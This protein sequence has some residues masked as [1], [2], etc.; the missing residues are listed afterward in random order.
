L[1]ASTFIIETEDLD[2]LNQLRAWYYTRFGPR[3]QV[4]NDLVDKMV[5][6]VWNEKRAW[7]MEHE[8]IN[9]QMVRMAPD[10]AVRFSQLSPIAR[11]ACAFAELARTLALPLL[12][13]YAARL[14][15]EFH[16]SMKTLLELQKTVPLLP[17]GATPPD[18]IQ[19]DSETNPCPDSDTPVPT[20]ESSEPAAETSNLADRPSVVTAPS[21]SPLPTAERTGRHAG[22]KAT[23]RVLGEPAGRGGVLHE[24][25]KYRTPPRRVAGDFS[26]DPFTNREQTP[27][28]R[29]H[30]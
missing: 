9:V 6:A 10:A 5:H 25:Q 24:H 23:T 12:H 14:S 29:T 1:T 13:R 15:N 3:D 30:I 21:H 2:E 20:G 22:L 16:R 18:P 8:S 19:P 11:A 27:P 26:A 28:E 7:A 4:E 17:A